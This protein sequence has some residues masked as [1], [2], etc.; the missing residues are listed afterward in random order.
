MRARREA[1]GV[2]L[3]SRV[4]VVAVVL[5]V[6]ACAEEGGNLEGSLGEVYDLSFETVR[7]RLYPSDLSIEYV[8]EHGEAVVRLTAR[9][10]P[11]ELT[12]SSTFDLTEGGDI[13]GASGGVSIPRLREGE[14]SLSAYAP[15]EGAHVRGSFSALFLAGENEFDLSGGF[16]ATIELV[17]PR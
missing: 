13:T 6:F 3:E 5:S 9:R 17:P 14:M 7:A 16:S 10:V 4:L 12:D 2:R 8:N 11:A 15:E 1:R